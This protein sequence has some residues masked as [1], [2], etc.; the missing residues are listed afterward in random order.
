M[1]GHIVATCPS[2]SQRS[3][4]EKYS[5][6]FTSHMRG[7][8]CHTDEQVFVVVGRTSDNIEDDVSLRRSKERD[9]TFSIHLG[10]RSSELHCRGAS[11]YC[12]RP[13]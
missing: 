8:V 2:H 12:M 1:F 11:E 13:V 4:A 9:D 3:N 6:N 10:V 7:S 5:D